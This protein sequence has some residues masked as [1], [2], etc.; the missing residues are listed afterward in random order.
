MNGQSRIYTYFVEYSGC[1]DFYL[2]PVILHVLVLMTV[3]PALY[4]CIHT[5]TQKG[6]ESKK[7]FGF[8]LTCLILVMNGGV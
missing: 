1:V 4:F 2:D 5:S 7:H 6:I 8:K 3:G